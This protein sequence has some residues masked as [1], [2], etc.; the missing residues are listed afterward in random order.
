M[1]VCKDHCA[2]MENAYSAEVR[3]W[4]FKI[5][6]NTNFWQFLLEVGKGLEI[7]SGSG[8]RRT[9]DSHRKVS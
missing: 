7:G 9:V 2:K 1:A 4:V 5:G 3:N 6:L 8:A